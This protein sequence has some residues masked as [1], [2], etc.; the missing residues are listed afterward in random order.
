MSLRVER[1]SSPA[2]ELEVLPEMGASILNLRAA[3]GRP[4]M[5]PVPLEAVRTSSQCASYTLLPFSNRIRDARFVFGGQEVALR[6]NT[7]DGLAQHGDVRNRPWQLLE[8]SDTHLRYGFD[9]RAFADLNWPWAF[10]AQIE[11]R[12]HGP[13]F[14]TTLTLTNADD[15]DMPAGMGL[16][17]YYVRVQDGVDATL[18]LGADLKYDTDE[19]LLTVGG[20]RPVR[21]DEDYRTPS[22][23]GGRFI[24]GTYT[25]W[26]GLTR[27][28]W[29]VRAL[30]VTADNVYSHSVVFTAPDGSLALEPVSHATD[31]FNLAAQ[32]VAGVDA[33]TL[34]PGQSLAGTVR[35]T[36][37]GDW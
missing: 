12:L 27:L 35:V 32:G 13:H 18:Q 20:A 15:R 31:A 34:S 3:S 7:D 29:G 11:Y 25:A 28:D 24:D 8:R 9:S 19:R 36:L 33:R 22:P 2:F 5:R 10:T 17:P 4:V 14:D 26:D 30:T 1:L 16:H 6:V 21:P 37:E 23:V